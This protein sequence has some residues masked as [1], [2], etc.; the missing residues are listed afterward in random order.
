MG[1]GS[2]RV[3]VGL[4]PSHFITF[5]FHDCPLLS[6]KRSK[7][8]NIISK[9]ETNKNVL[10][11]VLFLLVSTKDTVKVAARFGEL[12][13]SRRETLHSPRNLHEKGRDSR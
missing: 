3:L 5:T 9:I 4:I 13:T 10:T 8:K 7:Y 6:F 11:P 1:F 12:R 2:V